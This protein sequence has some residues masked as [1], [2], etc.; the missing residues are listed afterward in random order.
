MTERV[1]DYNTNKFIKDIFLC[2]CCLHCNLRSKWICDV[3]EMFTFV[4]KLGY[5]PLTLLELLNFH[6]TLAMSSSRF[7]RSC[8]TRSP[9]NITY[10]AAVY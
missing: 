4:N 2:S 10:L 6:L 8:Q 3:E 7:C 5:K 9:I 1:I